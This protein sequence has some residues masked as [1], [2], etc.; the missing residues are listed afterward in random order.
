MAGM[1]SQS[2]R[3]KMAK[4]QREQDRDAV[5][6]VHFETFDVHALA[7][8][9]ASAR[10]ER[11]RNAVVF[12]PKRPAADR[13]GEYEEVT[14]GPVPVNPRMASLSQQKEVISSATRAADRHPA[15]PFAVAA[16][17]PESVAEDATNARL[18]FGGDSDG[19][20]SDEGMMEGTGREFHTSQQAALNA[21]LRI[22]C[23][24]QLENWTATMDEAKARLM[25]VVADGPAAASTS[26]AQLK[27]YED[28]YQ[29]V[30]PLDDDA[31][32]AS[33]ERDL[34]LQVPAA[35][36]QRLVEELPV[37]DVEGIHTALDSLAAPFAGPG[38]A[39]PSARQQQRHTTLKP[40][41]TVAG[42]ATIADASL[43]QY[44][45]LYRDVLA[46]LRDELAAGDE[47][48]AES[49]LHAKDAFK[50][51]QAAAA[52]A[53]A[54]MAAASGEMEKAASFSGRGAGAAGGRRDHP[55][56]H[57]TA[58]GKHQKSEV[59]VLSDLVG[60][61]ATRHTLMEAAREDVDEH[62]AA[63]ANNA[64]IAVELTSE[65]AQVTAETTGRA[66][67]DKEQL[68][69]KAEEIQERMLRFHRAY[70]EAQASA[71]S[72]AMELQTQEQAVWTEVAAKVSEAMRLSSERRTLITAR[73]KAREE[74]ALRQRVAAQE[75]SLVRKRLFRTNE[76]LR[77]LSQHAAVCEHLADYNS[78]IRRLQCERDIQAEH[79]AIW[80]GQSAEAL[81]D[82]GE[83]VT[84]GEDLRSR[85]LNRL[86]LV[87]KEMRAAELD[88]GMAVDCFDPDVPAYRDIAE[89]MKGTCAALAVEVAELE[90][91]LAQTVE[92]AAPIVDT[93]ARFGWGSEAHVRDD[94]RS[95]RRKLRRAE[96]EEEEDG[97]ASPSPERSAPASVAADDSD[98]TDDSD[99]DNDD[100]KYAATRA[101]V[102]GQLK[103]QRK[104]LG[105]RSLENDAAEAQLTKVR[106]LT[107]AAAQERR[108]HEERVAQRRSA[109]DRQNT[110][111][112]GGKGDG[113][114]Q[115][116]EDA[117]A[118]AAEPPA[119]NSDEPEA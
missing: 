2:L 86:E 94:L 60:E 44:A 27:T 1:S 23:E 83:A 98:S 15:M 62:A 55:G 19:N 113:P 5:E 71:H 28:N 18:D 90:E 77:A 106:A 29:C 50:K 73:L 103:L 66:A 40:I 26:I 4:L 110:A 68:A 105:H 72:T 102:R 42:D 108:Q 34:G 65:L 54:A 69:G 96:L 84:V 56:A 75:L 70:L 114:Q 95:V 74:E 52:A 104:T 37:L 89:R 17:S 9:R 97:G 12:T 116:Q 13:E 76:A 53:K 107:A 111:T 80:R 91:T 14:P 46:P 115:Q 36:I 67:A 10:R 57:L 51:R 78:E 101:N 6:G 45:D 61:R 48:I 49:R 21:E 32:V 88:L 64:E 93:S 118:T 7:D 92:A 39:M 119:A 85:W 117:P 16:H 8:K 100:P 20:I 47:R 43:R 25:R 59:S 31:V 112:V 30:H 35:E 11:Q 63:S 38:Q 3:E 41:D 87:R 109:L 22:K 33:M 58:A 81:H 99:S 24:A 79:M 82:Y